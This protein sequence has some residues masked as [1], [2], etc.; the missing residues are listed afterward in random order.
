MPAPPVPAGFVPDPLLLASCQAS[1]DVEV[2]RNAAGSSRTQHGYAPEDWQPLAGYRG[3]P[4]W[5][6]GPKPGTKMLDGRDVPVLRRTALSPYPLALDVQHRLVWSDPDTGQ[7]RN[8]FLEAPSKN[9]AL[10]NHHW[11]LWLVEYAEP[12]PQGG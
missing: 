9:A 8:L 4:V 1:V 10:Q 7:V 2:D 12:I 3:I 5:L 6:G 11:T